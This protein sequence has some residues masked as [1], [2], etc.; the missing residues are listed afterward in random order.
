M[1]MTFARMRKHALTAVAVLVDILACLIAPLCAIPLGALRR[2]GFGRL[3]MTRATLRL[4]GI[5]PIRQHYHDAVVYA[6]D[7]QQPLGLER[8]L[9][10]VDL[11][12]TDQ[13][14]LLSQFNYSTEPKAIPDEDPGTGEFYYRNGAF[15]F[16]DAELLY[17]FIRFFKPT[18]IVE[19]GR[20]FSTL[21]ARKA[22]AV[23]EAPQ[24]TYR[25]KHVCIEPFE[26][27]WIASSGATVLQQ[28]VET[29]DPALFLSLTRTDILFI[30]SSHVIRPQGDV[31]CEY[32]DILPGLAKGVIVHVHDVFTPRDYPTDRVINKQR[33]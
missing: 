23:N 24:P 5:L 33:L 3:P 12:P 17:S 9:P 2:V 11:K 30:D 15:E 27:S 16:G 1:P 31:L 18:R 13:I 4:V 19:I 6:S 21:V 26:N 25:C 20:G 7:L 14:A 32:L 10:D 22:L 8:A 28:R 29:C